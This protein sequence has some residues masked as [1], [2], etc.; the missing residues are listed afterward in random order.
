MPINPTAEQYA[1]MFLYLIDKI[2]SNTKMKNNEKGVTVSSVKVHETD[3]G[4]AL[5]ERK[6]LSL[7]D[8]DINDFEFSE[9]VKVD[10][11]DPKMLEKVNGEGE[12]INPDPLKQV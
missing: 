7:I 9:G 4:Y 11:T 8:Y 12:F 1:L 2:L 5:A 3:T 10:W 6:D